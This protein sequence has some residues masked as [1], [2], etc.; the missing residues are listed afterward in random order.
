[1]CK[2]GCG[3][4]I[5]YLFFTPT[6]DTTRCT[7]MCPDCT[8]LAARPCAECNAPCRHMYHP[9]ETA[10]TPVHMCLQCKRCLHA[11]V[12]A[13]VRALPCAFDVPCDAFTLN[14]ERYTNRR[15]V[16]LPD[17]SASPCNPWS[18]TTYG[19]FHFACASCTKCNKPIFSVGGI[20]DVYEGA[21]WRVDITGES[22]AHH[23]RVFAFVHHPTCPE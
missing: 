17:Q 6:P 9:D 2:G 11:S 18:P 1:M 20:I 10:P 3:V 23:D 19:D 5:K 21:Q 13:F 12:D 22:S 14:L 16:I 4:E 15:F 8:K 7:Y